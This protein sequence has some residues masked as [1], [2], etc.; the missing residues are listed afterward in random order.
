M[1]DELRGSDSRTEAAGGS[2]RR[3]F[4]QG[5]GIAGLSAAVLSGTSSGTMSDTSSM[6][7]EPETFEFGGDRLILGGTRV[8]GD[9]GYSTIAAAWADAA[10]GDTVYVHSSYDAEEAGEQFPIQ[11]NYEEKEVMLT[12]GH[13]SGS[14][15]DASHTNAN[16]IEV[17]GRGMNDYRN[18]PLVQNL[19]IVGGNIG[20]RV[21][22]APYSTYN[23][24][25]FY[26]NGSHGVSIEPY[27]DPDSGRD[28]GTWGATFNDCQAWSCGD[29]GF[30][31]HKDALP[32]GTTFMNCKA[33]WNGGVG[34]NLRGYTNKIIGGTTQLNDSYGIKAKLGKG[35]LIQGVYLEGNSRQ[36]D[37]P[38]ELYA[39]NADG[40][41]VQN[42]YFNGI[43]PGPTAHDHDHVLRGVNVHDT[44]KLSV[45]DCT[46]RNYGQGF[47]SLF[48]CS[49]ADVYAASHYLLDAGDGLFATDVLGHGN[50]R[51]RSDGIVMPMD[52]SNVE[53]QHECDRGY[54][55]GKK[56]EGPAVWRDGEWH[57]TKTNTI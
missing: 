36:A 25:V 10:S 40:L 19:K 20:L 17:L 9:D 29:N 22:A 35:S 56:E 16:V 27:T 52:L 24:L 23:N 39:T 44:Q 28:K 54:H 12:G 53:G 51:P 1:T 2:T 45:R 8:V 4:M 50:V 34:F 46:V 3:K 21:R 18:N 37:F 32:H 49:D 33:T 14:V 30:N 48:S 57:V 43:N 15:I 7:D 47:I 41:S 26:K 55:I 42:C 13:P 5:L 38:V 11:L 31:T 6:D